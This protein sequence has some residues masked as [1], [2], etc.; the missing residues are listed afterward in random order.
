MMLNLPLILSRQG[1]RVPLSEYIKAMGDDM[2]NVHVSD[3]D[4]NNTCLLPGK[5]V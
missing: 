2:V 5:G 3:Y 4:T 1:E